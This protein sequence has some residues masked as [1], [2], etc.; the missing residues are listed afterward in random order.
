MYC[1]YMISKLFSHSYHR[2][3]SSKV[4][5]KFKIRC[6][7]SF[8]PRVL[9]VAKCIVNHFLIILHFHRC[10]VLIVAKCIVN[11][12]GE[13]VGV[14][15]G[16]VLIVAKCIVNLLISSVFLK[17]FIVLIVAKCIVN[18]IILFTYL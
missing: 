16:D 9:I 2:I 14:Q 7:K 15:I 1:K 6:S 11:V 10:F 8:S 13:Q 3:N 4:Y 5:C 18:N 12:G 17:K